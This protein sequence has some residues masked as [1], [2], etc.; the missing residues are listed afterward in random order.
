MGGFRRVGAVREPPLILSLRSSGIAVQVAMTDSLRLSFA[1][2]FVD[3]R[4]LLA[5][6]QL[7]L[8]SSK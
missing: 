8:S 1:L 2:F 3:H 6:L 5:K 7:K 4:R